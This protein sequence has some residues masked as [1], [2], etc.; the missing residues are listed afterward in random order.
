M[1]KKRKYTTFLLIDF[2][3][4][5]WLTGL[6]DLHFIRLIVVY[7]STQLALYKLDGSKHSD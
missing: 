2:S 7:Q 4:V 3:R 1:N 6:I 5:F